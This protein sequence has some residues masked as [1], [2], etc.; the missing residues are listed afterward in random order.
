MTTPPAL[1]SRMVPARTPRAGYADNLKVVL[2][3]AVIAGHVTLAFTGIAAWTLSEP[4]VR[5]PLLSVLRLVAIVGGLFAMALFFLIAGAFTPDSLRRKG[6]RRFLS[7][8][9]V[10]LGIPVLVFVLLM[11]PVVEYA[12]TDTAG[13]S[14]GFPAFVWFIWR[15]PAPGP[16]WFLGVLLFFSAVYAVART[17]SPATA[18]GPSPVRVR[19][20]AAGAVFVALAGYAIR[21]AVPLGQEYQHLALGQAPGWLTG[22][23]LG[24]LGSER[25]WFDA[26]SPR[27]SRWLFRAAWASA[28]GVALTLVTATSLGA[29]LEPFLG[30]PTW[31]AAIVSGLEGVLV[32]SMPLWL[33]DVSRRR[34]DRQGARARGLSRAAYAAFLVHQLVAVGAVLATR[35]VL[36]PPELEYVV[37]AALAVVG[38]FA[39]GA[40]LVRVPVVARVV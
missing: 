21:C 26:M 18:R 27:T 31:Q 25:G 40:L 36:W 38:S 10:R 14:E 17:A 6:P 2:V 16:T 33:F 1:T 32:V 22:F 11:A 30:G 8:R 20:L 5:D 37:A 35:A 39:I 9:A 28:G 3:A 12:D 13:W 23:T 19:D 29:E 15:H 34:F 24:V 7:D 4:P